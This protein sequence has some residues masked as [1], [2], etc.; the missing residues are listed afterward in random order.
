MSVGPKREARIGKWLRIFKARRKP[1]DRQHPSEARTEDANDLNR[2]VFSCRFAAMNEAGVT[3]V[4]GCSWADEPLN[5]KSRVKFVQLIRDSVGKRISVNCDTELSNK[6]RYRA[7]AVPRDPSD[8][9]DRG[10]LRL[11][12]SNHPPKLAFNRPAIIK[13]GLLGCWD[14]PRNLGDAGCFADDKVQQGQG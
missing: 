3:V 13:V 14:C 10:I 11:I 9:N 6:K 7:I 8:P 1:A 2:R 12:C 4:G 5:G